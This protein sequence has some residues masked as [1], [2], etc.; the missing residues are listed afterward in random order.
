MAAS[1]GVGAMPC[2]SQTRCSRRRFGRRQSR[3]DEKG[4]A[5]RF[6]C[7][8]EPAHHGC[9]ALAHDPGTEQRVASCQRAVDIAAG[10]PIG[11]RM[12][13][14]WAR[15]VR[16][17]QVRIGPPRLRWAWSSSGPL[18]AVCG[19]GSTTE[20]FKLARAARIGRRE[21]LIRHPP[22][23]LPMDAG[24]GSPM[25]TYGTIRW[26]PAG[27]FDA[28]RHEPTGERGDPRSLRRPAD[29]AR[30]LRSNSTPTVP[31]PLPAGSRSRSDRV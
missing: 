1:A 22:L 20:T 23:R 9:P 30:T 21:R 18:W 25:A 3:V 26:P 29:C 16:T 24:G 7:A 11:V 31:D 8:S 5:V 28:R 13:P 27:S 14:F 4:R 6:A 12:A 15:N 10:A 17:R 2:G 19:G